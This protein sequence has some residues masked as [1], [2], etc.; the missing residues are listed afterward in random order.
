MVLIKRFTYRGD[1]NE[2]WSNR[3]YLT[4]ADPTSNAGWLTLFNQLAQIER[5]LYTSEHLITRAY[6]YTSDSPNAAA[7]YIRDLKAQNAEIPGEH[8]ASGVELPGDCAGIVRWRTARLTS[9]G[10]NI[11]LRKFMHG[12]FGVD[13]TPDNVAAT[14]LAKYTNFAQWLASG[15]ETGGRTIRGP[16]QATETILGSQGMP[17]TT[18]R[19]LKRRGK[20]PTPAP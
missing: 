19:T 2:E 7:V 12:V 1:P 3:Y 20:R 17:F 6:G 4:G 14:Q 5:S 15:A 13:G 10:K 11:Y 9:K 8:V 16:G 18:T